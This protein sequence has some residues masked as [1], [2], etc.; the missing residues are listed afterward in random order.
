MKRKP[1]T[2]DEEKISRDALRR[3][4]EQDV[5]EEEREAVHRVLRGSEETHREYM[6]VSN[7]L[8]SLRRLP[9]WSPPERVW[10]NIQN[11]I[12]DMS[13]RRVRFPWM[14]A[15]PAWGWAA[16]T[17]PI[18][19]LVVLTLGMGN[20]Q[21]MEFSS[22][23]VVVEDMNGFRLEFEQY[24]AFHELASESAPVRESLLSFCADT[25]FK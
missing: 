24:A 20:Y 11:R 18:V 14:Y 19:L 5:S 10:D 17:A 7:Y 9:S 15:H 3:Y 21:Q 12:A 1:K 2:F 22:D 23:Y 25:S 8:S 4:L 13:P 6:K 16:K